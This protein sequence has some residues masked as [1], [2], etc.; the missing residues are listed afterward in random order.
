MQEST[1]LDVKC[2]CEFLSNGFKLLRAEIEVM[3]GV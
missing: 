2:T 1:L 3:V